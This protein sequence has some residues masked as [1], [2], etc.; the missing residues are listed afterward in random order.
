MLLEQGFENSHLNAPLL[1]FVWRCAADGR[2]TRESLAW[3]LTHLGTNSIFTRRSRLHAELHSLATGNRCPGKPARIIE[4]KI[5]TL[6]MA[7]GTITTEGGHTYTGDLIIGAD[8]INSA[9]RAAILST[10]SLAGSVDVAGGAAAVPS[11]VAAYLCIVP[12]S[13]IRDD[14]VLAFQTGE[15]SGMATF[16]S[17][18]GRKQVLVF[19]ADAE[20]FQ[21]IAYHPEDGW[22]EQF[23]QSGSSIIKDIPAER[24]VQ[25][26]VEFHPSIQKMFASAA[27]RDV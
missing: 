8:G 24:A 2:V 14:P 7:A 21:I 10:N 22:V 15:K 27:T 19:P 20:N 5:T 25:D 12:N 3:S 16:H 1:A 11:G 18:D 9:V 17:D 26:F 4:E 13:V 6:D 23:T